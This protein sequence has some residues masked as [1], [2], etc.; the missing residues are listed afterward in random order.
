MEYYVKYGDTLYWLAK[1]FIYSEHQTGLSID[2]LSPSVGY[3]LAQAFG[4]TEEGRWLQANAPQLKNIFNIIKYLRR[5]LP[6]H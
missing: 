1:R 3:G 5:N 4:D 6:L 2:V